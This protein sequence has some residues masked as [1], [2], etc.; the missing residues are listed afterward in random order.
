VTLR[1]LPRPEPASTP[2]QQALELVSHAVAI[3]KHDR[4]TW[5][6]FLDC[7]VEIIAREVASGVD[8]EPRP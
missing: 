4:R 3:A 6:V 5:T 1:R 7:A 8:R 2:L